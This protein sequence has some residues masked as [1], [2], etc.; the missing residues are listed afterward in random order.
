MSCCNSCAQAEAGLPHAPCG[1][2]GTMVPGASAQAARFRRYRGM[3]Y[4]ENRR[5]VDRWTGWHVLYGAWA[6]GRGWSMQRT[7]LW[8]AV[9]ELV[10]WPFLE[11]RIEGRVPE[12]LLNAT[13]DVGAALAGYVVAA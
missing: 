1:T 12:S 3:G 13:A 11:S 4:Q 2:A 10:E 9:F 7:L 8:A 5:M 6:A